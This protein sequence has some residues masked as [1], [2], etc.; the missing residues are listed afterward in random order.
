MRNGYLLTESDEITI[1]APTMHQSLIT[2]EYRGPKET[3]KGMKGARIILRWGVERVSI[4]LES[5]DMK[6]AATEYLSGRDITVTSNFFLPENFVER[7]CKNSSNIIA[8]IVEFESGA[9][10]S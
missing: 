7:H 5:R 10:L 2:V 3:R 4:A 6:V 8:L 9:T 1:E